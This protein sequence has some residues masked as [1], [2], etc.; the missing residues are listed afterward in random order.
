MAA[1]DSTRRK[2][3]KRQARLRLSL[4]GMRFYCVAYMRDRREHF[5]PRFKSRAR[6]E[7]ARAILAAKHG[8]AIILID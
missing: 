2:E 7:Q 4:R 1:S 8:R 6:D 5:S 3:L